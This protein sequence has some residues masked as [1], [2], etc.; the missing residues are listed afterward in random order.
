MVIFQHVN[1]LT[2]VRVTTQ[3]PATVTEKTPQKKLHV[4][5]DWEDEQNNQLIIT[6]YQFNVQTEMKRDGP[7][8]KWVRILIIVLRLT[9]WTHIEST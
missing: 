8:W 7:L 4:T 1:K 9:H 5:E 3:K 6:N 2:S